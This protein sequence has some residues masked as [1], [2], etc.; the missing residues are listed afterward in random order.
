MNNTDPLNDLSFR[1]L[2]CASSTTHVPSWNARNRTTLAHA[3]G[4]LSEVSSSLGWMPIGGLGS[5]K[6]AAPMSS[7]MLAL[8]QRCIRGEA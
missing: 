2:N 4:Q 8:H 1:R 6:T 7:T 5:V 3:T